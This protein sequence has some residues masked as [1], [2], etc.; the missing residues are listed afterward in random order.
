MRILKWVIDRVHGRAGAYET[1]LGWVPRR[2]DFDLEGLPGIPP[3]K[4]EQLQ[5]INPAEWRREILHQDELFMNLYPYLPK[6]M[7]FQREL[8]VARL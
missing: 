4:F 1:P 7:I 5:T 6:E 3:E 8:L 2:Q